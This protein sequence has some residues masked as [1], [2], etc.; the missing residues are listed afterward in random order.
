MCDAHPLLIASHFFLKPP[1]KIIRANIKGDNRSNFCS[2]EAGHVNRR[3]QTTDPIS[4]STK[5]TIS[6][7]A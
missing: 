2:V 7:R 4:D 1:G 6:E 3:N 5:A